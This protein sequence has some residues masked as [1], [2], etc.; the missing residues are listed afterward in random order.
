[1]FPPC[2]TVPDDTPVHAIE[3]SNISVTVNAYVASFVIVLPVSTIML[4]LI[5]M[6]NVPGG[7]V[8]EVVTVNELAQVGVAVASVGAHGEL[9]K[10]TLTPVGR[11]AGATLNVTGLGALAP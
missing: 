10:F 2:V 8:P 5:G 6:T 9:A 7:V 11:F 3:K 4:A 1:M